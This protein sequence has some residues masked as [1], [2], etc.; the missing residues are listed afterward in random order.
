MMH[1]IQSKDYSDQISDGLNISAPACSDASLIPII[2]TAAGVLGISADHGAKILDK[3]TEKRNWWLLAPRISEVLTKSRLER[4]F[5]E[6]EK[7][8]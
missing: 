6:L 4:T 7:A 8:K 2:G 5:K 3:A 1:A